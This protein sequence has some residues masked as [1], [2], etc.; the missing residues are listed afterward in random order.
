[1][2]QNISFRFDKVGSD[3]IKICVKTG[4]RSVCKTFKVGNVNKFDKN[5]FKAVFTEYANTYNDITAVDKEEIRD[6][7]TKVF[8]KVNTEHKEPTKKELKEKLFELLFSLEN[9][10]LIGCKIE[11]I[12]NAMSYIEAGKYKLTEILGEGYDYKTNKHCYVVYNTD[13]DRFAIEVE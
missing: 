12:G 4:K 10:E 11:A 8:E 6:L 13:L 7:I 2:T 9:N 5:R 1:M 3:K